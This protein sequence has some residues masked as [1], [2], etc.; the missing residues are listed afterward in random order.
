MKAGVKCE[1][2]I[3]VRLLKVWCEAA[4]VGL[5]G[6]SGDGREDGG[7]VDDWGGDRRKG[8]GEGGVKVRVKVWG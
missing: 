1:G 8:W 4:C 7:G 3:F 6:F 2:R 5:V